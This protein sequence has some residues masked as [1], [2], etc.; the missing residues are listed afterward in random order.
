MKN[1]VNINGELYE[2]KL[3]K[4]YNLCN[5]VLSIVA[6][7]PKWEF[8]R[9]GNSAKVV[10]LECGKE[11]VILFVHGTVLQKQVNIPAKDY[12]PALDA[13]FVCA[14]NIVETACKNAKVKV[15]FSFVNL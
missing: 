3:V 4:E 9:Y 8:E 6:G 1:V 10:I 12:Y 11:F 15:E 13:A 5:K 14:E 7:F 2:G